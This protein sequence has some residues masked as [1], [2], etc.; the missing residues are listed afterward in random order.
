MWTLTGVSDGGNSLWS[1][2]RTLIVLFVLGMFTTAAIAQTPNFPPKPPAN[3]AAADATLDMLTS[4]DLSGMSNQW[5][6]DL[7]TAVDAELKAEDNMKRVEAMRKVIFLATYYPDKANFD[8]CGTELYNIYRFN[9]KEDER[10][11]ALAALYASGDDSAMR[12]IAYHA[13]YMR[14]APWENS[15]LVRHVTEAAIMRYFG[16]PTVTVEPPSPIGARPMQ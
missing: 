1:V 9:K 15:D 3:L 14:F 2:V 10:V 4:H 6:T 16:T 12:L 13:P 11:M 7:S 5:W 8:R